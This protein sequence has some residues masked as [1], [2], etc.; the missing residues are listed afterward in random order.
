MSRHSD[1]RDTIL[2]AAEAVVLT[3]GAGHLTLD[4]VAEAAGISK[5]GLLHRFP[6]KEALVGAMVA[7]Q[8]ERCEGAISDMRDTLPDTPGREL[9]AY[10][11]GALR[12]AADTKRICSALLAAAANQPKLLAPVRENSR[13]RLEALA[14]TTGGKLE[15]AAVIC[16]ATD[17]LWLM[18]LLG[19]SP[20]KPA[21]RERIINE[22][23]QLAE[24]HAVADRGKSQRAA[25]TRPAVRPSKPAVKR[26]RP[27]L[28]VA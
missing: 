14:T 6:S 10:V 20:F 8:I 2:A 13:H 17:G 27:T 22:L 23:L 25:P 24:K 9:R 21:E 4:A 5:G 15:R 18:E 16:L 19:L 28:V 3:A 12:D 26:R 1:S 7:R 11:L